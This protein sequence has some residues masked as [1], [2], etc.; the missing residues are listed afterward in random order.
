MLASVKPQQL[1]TI[2]TKVEAWFR[3]IQAQN[4]YSLQAELLLH[5]HS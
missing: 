1:E 3:S 4:F 5:L 2:F